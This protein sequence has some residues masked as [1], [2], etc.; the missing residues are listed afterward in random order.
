MKSIKISTRIVLLFAAIMVFSFIGEYLRD[1][2][3]D[4]KC[5]GSIERIPDTYNYKGCNYANSSY[6]D[7]TWHWGYR[8]WIFCL[9]GFC[10]SIVQAVGIINLINK[11]DA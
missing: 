6:H 3:G 1:F 4:W 7:P 5:P 8:H 2:F 9:M 10:L 11:E